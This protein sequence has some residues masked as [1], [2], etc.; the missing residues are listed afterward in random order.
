MAFKRREIESL[1]KSKFGFVEDEKRSDDH[2][3]YVLRIDDL[4]D[5]ATKVSH[6]G[7]DI[8]KVL[9]GKIA[10]QLRV[11]RPF[12]IGMFKCD[13]D[14]EAYQKRVRENPVPP[15]DVRF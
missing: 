6:S 14:K 9:E 10:R 8:G 3:W 2:K 4:P 5:I 7:K 11:P 13:E 1:L 15:W 12:F